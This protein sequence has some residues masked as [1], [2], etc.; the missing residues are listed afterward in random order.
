M[1]AVER[2]HEGR[3]PPVVGGAVVGVGHEFGVFATDTLQLGGQPVAIGLRL[4]DGVDALG[5]PAGPPVLAERAR[6]GQVAALD[7]WV[8][9]FAHIP[10]DPLPRSA[11]TWASVAPHWWR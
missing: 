7:V 8:V 2:A 11:P 1:E 4:D 5:D 10:E 9:E 3:V 6:L